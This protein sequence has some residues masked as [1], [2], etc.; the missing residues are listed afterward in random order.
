MFSFPYCAGSIQFLSATA[1]VVI[2][3]TTTAEEVLAKVRS[4]VADRANITIVTASDPVFVSLGFPY[5]FDREKMADFAF[6]FLNE[7]VSS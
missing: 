2:R 4:V 5:G 1:S 7:C 3:V 6:F